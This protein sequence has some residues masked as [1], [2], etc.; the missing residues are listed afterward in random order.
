MWCLAVAR[1]LLEYG[2]SV[3]FYLEFGRTPKLRV[4]L[5]ISLRGVLEE[6]FFGISK[7]RESKFHV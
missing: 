7:F 4:H 6:G 3:P 1:G 5:A 2:P